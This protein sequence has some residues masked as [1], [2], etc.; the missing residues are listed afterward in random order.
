MEDR[1]KRKRNEVNYRELD[2]GESPPQDDADFK[3]STGKKP[4]AKKQKKTKTG[5]K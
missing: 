2:E 4:L 3:K 5:A 1:T